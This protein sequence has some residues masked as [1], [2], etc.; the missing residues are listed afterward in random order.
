MTTGLYEFFMKHG[1][2]GRTAKDVYEH[3]FYTARKQCTNS[4]W[5]NNTYIRKG[6][7]LG[8][9]S[10]EQAI[11]FLKTH[12]LIEYSL[13]R[14]THSQVTRCYIVIETM[15]VTKEK[16]DSVKSDGVKSDRSRSGTQ[17]LKRQ[18]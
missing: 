16:S 6:I 10:I 15:K 4:V 12:G 17:M 14:D 5:A 11:I 2:I 8:V 7:G 9:K 3:R 1:K 18:K 13:R